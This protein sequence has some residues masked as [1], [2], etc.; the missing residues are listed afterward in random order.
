M[1]FLSVGLLC[2]SF[3]FGL[4]AIIAGGLHRHEFDRGN[5][6][7]SHAGAAVIMLALTMFAATLA[8]WIARGCL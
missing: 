8:G 5:T 3:V 1:I 4:G 6:T 2:L 7:A